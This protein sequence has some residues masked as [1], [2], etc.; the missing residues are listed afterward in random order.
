MRFIEIINKSP[1]VS[2][3]NI[4]SVIIEFPTPDH[5]LIKFITSFIELRFF[6]DSKDLLPQTK[7]GLNGPSLRVAPNYYTSFKHGFGIYRQ[8]RKGDKSGSTYNCR[9]FLAYLVNIEQIYMNKYFN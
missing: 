3:D 6:S 1:L 5:D 9:V 7:F 4:S 2:F 8:V